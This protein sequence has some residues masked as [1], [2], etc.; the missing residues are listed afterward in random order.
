MAIPT[1]HPGLVV[2]Y[3][4]LWHHESERGQD[5]GLKDRPCAIVLARE[6]VADITVVTVAPVTHRPPS[7]ASEAIE[8]PQLIKTHLGLDEVPSW[9]VLTEVNSFVWPGSDLKPIPGS[10][11]AQFAYGVLPPRFFAK[12]RT[13]LLE[14]VRARRVRIVDRKE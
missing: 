1:P 11:P 13:A 8:M 14:A 9:I 7:D 12:L 3:A 10:S 6:V 2:S 5:H 4:Y